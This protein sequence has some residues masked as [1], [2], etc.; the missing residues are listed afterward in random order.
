MTE[1]EAYEIALAIKEEGERK[2]FRDALKA[3]HVAMTDDPGVLT[4]TPTP[5]PNP[6]PKPSGDFKLFEDINYANRPNLQ[7]LGLEPLQLY[8]EGAFFNDKQRQGSTDFSLP[9]P[10]RVAAAAKGA[11]D[12]SII[13][14]ERWWSSDQSGTTPPPQEGIAAYVKVLSDYRQ[15]LASGKKMGLY[16]TIPT[17]NYWGPVKGGTREL[18]WKDGNDKL[19]PLGGLVDATFPSIYTFYAD[20][21]GWE[22]Y[23]I[24]Q[25][26]EAKRIAPDVPCYP[27]LWPEYHPG[28]GPIER[29]FFRLQIQLCKDYADGAVI[30]T[31]SSTKRIDFQDIP[32]WWEA[33]TDFL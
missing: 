11:R 29:D 28:K 1:E 3:Y 32:G 16:G 21:D 23:A 24:A 6:K 13:D 31:L 18:R 25:I 22:K 10:G 7:K 26:E 20:R 15:N 19:K 9:L 2:A 17:R 14:I 8:Y 12:W 33:V 30:W 27:F 4:P 5:K